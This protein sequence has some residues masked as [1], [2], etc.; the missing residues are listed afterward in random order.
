MTNP[1][2][3]L[4]LLA[5]SAQQWYN[6]NRVYDPVAQLDRALPCGGKGYAFEP[7]RGRH[8]IH[9]QHALVVLFCGKTPCFFLFL[10]TFTPEIKPNF[11]I[12]TCSVF[13][14]SGMISALPFSP[15]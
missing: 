14:L 3:P 13:Q 8:G 15:R 9:H 12:Y 7:H 6:T 1:V 11:Y 5:I 10:P 2:T 4:D